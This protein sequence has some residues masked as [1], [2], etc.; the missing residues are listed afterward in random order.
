MRSGPSGATPGLTV[1][2]TPDELF[3]VHPPP[4]KI[5]VV[6]SVRVAVD[7][8]SAANTTDG[9]ITVPSTFVICVVTDWSL[10]LIVVV[11]VGLDKVGSVIVVVE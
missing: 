2:T 4:A 5:T 8:S 10:S 3:V 7:V 6:P 1:V 11:T 9:V